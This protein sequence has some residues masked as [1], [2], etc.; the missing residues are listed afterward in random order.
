MAFAAALTKRRNSCMWFICQKS[1]DFVSDFECVRP[2]MYLRVLPSFNRT[3][4]QLNVTF[5]TGVTSTEHGFG[6]SGIAVLHSRSCSSS[7]FKLGAC[8]DVEDS[9]QLSTYSYVQI[10]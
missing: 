8:D 7:Q 4:R 1:Y 5:S 3:Y 10:R 9:I 2:K 6:S